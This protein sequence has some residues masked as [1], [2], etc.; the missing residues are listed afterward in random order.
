[1]SE[2]RVNIKDLSPWALLRVKDKNWKTTTFLLCEI[3][4]KCWKRKVIGHRQCVY[5]WW[6]IRKVDWSKYYELIEPETQI[7][8][9]EKA[10]GKPKRKIKKKEILIYILL[11]T[12][13]LIAIWLLYL[14]KRLAK[15]SDDCVV[16]SVNSAEETT[17][18]KS[19]ELKFLHYTD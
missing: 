2:V 12:I 6:V 9:I 5:F 18:D 17:L 10:E 7:D 1:M 19:W 11:I 14:D 3:L 13:P 8:N 15:N 16:C 4:W